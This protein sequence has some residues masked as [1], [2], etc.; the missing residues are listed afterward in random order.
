MA[1]ETVFGL[2]RPLLRLTDNLCEEQPLPW[3]FCRSDSLSY[4]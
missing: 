2:S 3:K 1:L 4:E